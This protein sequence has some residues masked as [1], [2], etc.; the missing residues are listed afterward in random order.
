[1]R[2]QLERRGVKDVPDPDRKKLI[3]EA[4]EVFVRLNEDP[5][6]KDALAERDAFLARGAAERE[7]YSFVQK[8]WAGT[9][10]KPRSKNS[11]AI[12]WLVGLALA[13]YL[14]A[15]PARNLLLADFSTSGTVQEIKL[16]S[17][18]VAFLDAATAIADKTDSNSR[19]VKIL[20]G[21]ALFDV[22]SDGR[23][24]VVEIGDALVEVVGT[25]FE[26]SAI[27]DS[28]IV[29]VKEGVVR[30]KLNG[31]TWNLKQGTQ[32]SWEDEG[33]GDVSQI[34]PDSVAL[35][36]KN[37]LVADGLTFSQVAELID[38]RF[39]GR[40]IIVDAALAKSKVS[41]TINLENPEL[42]LQALAAVRG[43]RIVSI[44]LIG[45]FVLP[46]K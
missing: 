42:A 31:E 7:V 20:E 12:V 30:V 27:G 44:P 41:G 3:D 6:D 19:Q 13:S 25:V 29:S 14:F 45:R 24:F 1:M 9:G 33:G 28:V 39:S 15:A 38:R 40:I 16:A 22:N 26:A 46:P 43:A 4:A 5:V 21:T 34:D 2:Q 32:W 35:W 18:D 8:A 36:R 11:L 37:R 10:R 23:D 17:G